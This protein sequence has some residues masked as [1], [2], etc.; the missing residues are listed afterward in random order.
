MAGAMCHLFAHSLGLADAAGVGEWCLMGQEAEEGV[1][2][3]PVTLG[4]ASREALGWLGRTNRQL[5]VV[6]RDTT[7]LPVTDLH[8]GGHVVRVLCPP[9]VA[10]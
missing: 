5:L 10:E 4:A 2:Q 9:G 6:T 1:S 3:R 7:D 8:S